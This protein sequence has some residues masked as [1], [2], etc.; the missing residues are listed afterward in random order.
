ML[1]KV[2]RNSP[3][4][5]TAVLL[6][7]LPRPLDLTCFYFLFFHFIMKLGLASFRVDDSPFAVYSCCN[8]LESW[9]SSPVTVFGK[10]A[11]E[12]E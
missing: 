7:F 6:S 10:I 9:V 1:Y 11:N 8:P 12:M 5:L 4:I 2:Y 3:G